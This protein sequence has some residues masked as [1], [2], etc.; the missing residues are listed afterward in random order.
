MGFTSSI[1][2][3]QRYLLDE[4][5]RHDDYSGQDSIKSQIIII[6]KWLYFILNVFGKQDNV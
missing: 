4:H 3:Y 2:H 1:H 6:I 5:F